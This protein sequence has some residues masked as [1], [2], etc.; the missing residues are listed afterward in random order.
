M[1]P[2]ETLEMKQSF[3]SLSLAKMRDKDKAI[4]KICK[5]LIYAGIQYRSITW[6]RGK[7][8]HPA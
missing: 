7:K 4:S 6:S 5:L 1:L 8:K 2:V 3:L